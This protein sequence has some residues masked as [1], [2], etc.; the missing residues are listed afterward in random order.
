MRRLVHANTSRA[1]RAVRF[2]Q[3]RHDLSS[4]VQ[5]NPELHVLENR[6][7]ANSAE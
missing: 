5:P 7:F 4:P 6:M 1:K 2:P 3:N